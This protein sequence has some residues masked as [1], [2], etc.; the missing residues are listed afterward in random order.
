MTDK[1]ALITG[2]S[3]GLGEAFANRLAAQ[4]YN[5]ILVARRKERLE[6]LAAQ[7]NQKY[8]ITAEAFPADLSSENDLQN[9]EKRIDNLDGLEIL[10]N[11]AGFGIQDRFYN[12]GLEKPLY[13]IQVHIIAS[14]RITHRV[15]PGMIARNRGGIINVASIAAFLPI[16]S[17]AYSST[18]VFLV[19]FS[20]ALQSELNDTRL[21]IQA[22][23]P[24]FFYSE[25]HDTQELTNFKR[26]RM[27]GFLWLK[28][29]QVVDHSLKKLKRGPVI[30][31]PGFQYKLIAYLA[32]SPLTF[33][34]LYPLG[35]WFLGKR[36]FFAQGDGK[37][38]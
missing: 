30:C 3:S 28:A 37:P 1:T 2:A 5:L 14:V 10:V 25:F 21:R 9:L 26:S 20:L 15:L 17:V 16:R 18:K 32:R 6:E 36:P 35:T 7:L 4:N 29:E 13:M 23:C 11:N 8:N 31:V 38:T 34:L 33:S 12:G 27:P 22:L 24:G 19:N